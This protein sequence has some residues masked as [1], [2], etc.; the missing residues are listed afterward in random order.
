MAKE[1]GKEC[2]KKPEKLFLVCSPSAPYLLCPP[3]TL[4]LEP[5]LTAALQ[6]IELCAVEKS[7]PMLIT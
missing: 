1:S 4:D 7:D 3:H 5:N 6:L 2:E